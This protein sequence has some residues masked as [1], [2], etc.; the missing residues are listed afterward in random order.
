MCAA[1]LF[2]F[3]F[4]FLPSSSYLSPAAPP[5]PLPRPA[6]LQPEVFAAR[7]QS[8][9]EPAPS[10]VGHTGMNYPAAFSPHLIIILSKSGGSDH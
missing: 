7:T 9:R 3:F 2:F 8:E 6:L 4:F 1:V 5:R 10:P